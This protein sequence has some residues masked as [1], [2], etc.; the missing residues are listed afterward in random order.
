MAKP[1]APKPVASATTN[2]TTG[3][4]VDAKCAQK[5]KVT[6]RFVITSKPELNMPYAVAIGGAVDGA[7]KDRAFGV[8]CKN[9]KIEFYAESGKEVNLYLNSDASPDFRKEPVYAVTVGNGPLEVVITEKK[10]KHADKD[11][12]ILK[13]TKTSSPDKNGVAVATQYYGAPLTG[14][15]WLKVAHKYSVDEAK[16]IIPA[17][18]IAEIRAAVLKFYDGSLSDSSPKLSLIVP[19]QSAPGTHTIVI[20][21]NKSESM[22]NVSANILAATDLYKDVLPRV[23]PSGF[24]ALLEAARDAEIEMIKLTSTW[25]PMI[26]SIAHR[27][28]LGLDVNYLDTTQLNREE[29]RGKKPTKAADENV[30]EEERRLFAEKEKADREL[31]TATA[32][33]EALEKQQQELERL[34]KTNP[35]KVDPIKEAE[36]KQQQQEARERVTT[37]SQAKKESDE[38]WNQERDKNEPAKVKGYRASL[39]KCKCV[40]QIFDPWFMDNDT[41]DEVPAIP[42]EQRKTPQGGE[43]NET[44]HAHHLHITVHEPKIRK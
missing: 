41:Q 1:N 26:G 27:A 38:A 35:G 10:G 39:S 34:K 32:N 19:K 14:D 29:L 4:C 40:S 6:Y 20:D 31:K 42:N 16:A 2:E 25:R 5:H 33:K 24:V 21:P 44:L 36:L 18:T 12:P 37:T 13:E 17:A 15:I 22:G 9:G 23:H 28:G 30:S 43:S 8:A 3:T 7:F 11:T